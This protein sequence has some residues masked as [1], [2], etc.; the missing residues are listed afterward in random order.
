M[1]MRN[2]DRKSSPRGVKHPQRI[3]LAAS[4]ANPLSWL[5]TRRIRVRSDCFLRDA[6]LG[7]RF[8]SEGGR[9]QIEVLD[10]K[11]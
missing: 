8:G 7:C 3:P 9:N 1:E 5:S 10:E 4:S 11:S 6:E 2:L